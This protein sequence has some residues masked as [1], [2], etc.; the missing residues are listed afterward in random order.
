A[1]A[2]LLLLNAPLAA[3]AAVALGGVLAFLV[4]NLPPARLFLGDEGSLLLGYVLWLVPLAAFAAAP[5]ARLLIVT[6]CLCAFPLVNAGIVSLST[7]RTHPGTARRLVTRTMDGPVVVWRA[8]VPSTYSK[9]YLGR[10]FA[11]AVFT[12][13]AS[14]AALRSGPTDVV[15]A[16]SPPLVVVIPGWIKATLGRVPWIFEVRDLWPESAVT[17]GVVRARS[18]LTRVFYWLERA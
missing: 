3:L 15:I 1:L 5:S 10:R 4:F 18:P 6:G 8:H 9:S 2:A 16:T 17:T 13:T 14:L 12:L 7:G 11:Y